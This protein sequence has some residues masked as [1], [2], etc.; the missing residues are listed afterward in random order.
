[1]KKKQ[2]KYIMELNNFNYSLEHYI[3]NNH[4][5][6]YETSYLYNYNQYNKPISDKTLVIIMN[7]LLLILLGLNI[8]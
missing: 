4:N 6:E 3:L 2:S 5:S 1:M 8:R 7:F